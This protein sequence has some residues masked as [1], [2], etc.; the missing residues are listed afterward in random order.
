MD[1]RTSKKHAQKPAAANVMRE[2]RSMQLH[3]QRQ[4]Q[5]RNQQA[6]SEPAPASRWS[7]YWLGVE[8][9]DPMPH[10]SVFWR[11]V[12][13]AATIGIFVLAVMT[14]MY[15]ARPVLLPVVLAVTLGIVLTPLS[16]W[17]VRRGIPASISAVFVVAALLAA[18][19][20]VVVF[21]SDAIREWVTKA[22]EWI[23]LLKERLQIFERPA[24]ALNSLR[25]AI[26]GP[27]EASAPFKFDLNASLL[28]PVLAILTP[29][30]GQLILFIG[31]LVFFLADP[32]NLKE[33]VVLFGQNRETR[34]RAIRIV[35]DI[36]R[37]LVGHFGVVTIV[38]VCL[39][40]ALAIATWVIG[41]PNPLIW[42]LMAALLNYVP[43]IGAGIVIA[44]LF[45]VGL[46]T[47]DTLSQALI[48]P[49]FYLAL[50]TIEGQFIVPS[51]LG[52]RLTLSP[53]TIFVAI[54][55]WGWLWGAF[56]ALLAVPL[57]IVGMIVLKHLFPKMD[58]KLPG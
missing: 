32:N 9:A 50:A 44:C 13:R 57:L 18:G 49:G 58:V 16:N 10:A 45:A 35:K 41:L 23:P 8:D 5:Q 14:A 21:L 52:K 4:Q 30:A 17:A 54:G 19:S 22:P 25:D 46:I 56:G 15:F 40:I 6:A 27:G 43:Y 33:Y 31:T 1:A 12:T 24:A 39:G 26:T 28:Q 11:G 7:R 38:N 48:A 53:L 47:F 37:N 34:L 2:Q 36:E 3:E 29:A 51:I 20:F 42:G 55:F